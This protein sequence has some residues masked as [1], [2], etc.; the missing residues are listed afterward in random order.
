MRGNAKHIPTTA[1][2]PCPPDNTSD[3]VMRQVNI[4]STFRALDLGV[5]II[6][7]ES[8][9]EIASWWQTP[10]SA[11]AVFASTG[12]IVEGFAEEIN[13]EIRAYV[14]SADERA[15]M[16]AAERDNTVVLFA[17]LAYVKACEVDGS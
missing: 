15:G 12:R 7:P 8:A 9:Q 13:A 14:S 16:G 2:Q 6:H 1:T 4:W 3:Y 11:F 5:K 10:R 17:L